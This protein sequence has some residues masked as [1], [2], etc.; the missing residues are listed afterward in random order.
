M[1]WMI[2]AWFSSGHE[3]VS[4]TAVKW[5]WVHFGSSPKSISVPVGISVNAELLEVVPD[6]SLTA[7]TVILEEL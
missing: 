3:S 7:P 5:N 6:A 1:F 4:L 2:W